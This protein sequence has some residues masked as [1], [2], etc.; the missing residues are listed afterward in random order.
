MLGCCVRGLLLGD[1]V[2]WVHKVKAGL[3]SV[4][5]DAPPD[6]AVTVTGAV[7]GPR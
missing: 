2:G 4:D 5:L 6:D 1:S 3:T 7:G